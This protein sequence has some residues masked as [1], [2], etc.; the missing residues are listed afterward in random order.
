MLPRLRSLSFA[1]AFL[2]VA[3]VAVAAEHAPARTAARAAAIV[4]PTPEDVAALRGGSD[5]SISP[6]GTRLVYSLGTATLDP[7][8]RPNDKDTDGGWKRDRQVWIV[9]LAGGPPQQLTHGV[10]Q[11][12]S[13]VWSPDGREVAFLR[14]VKGKSVLHVIV[15]AGGEAQVVPTGTLEPSSVRWSPDGK[16]FAFLASAESSKQK[17]EEKWR[18]GGVVDWGREYESTS[19]WVVP[20]EGGEP[21]RL[22][23]DNE[24]VASFEWSPDGTRFAV[25]S[26]PS[27]D[28]YEESNH[29]T[30]R[31]IALKDGATIGVLAAKAEDYSNLRWSPDGRKLA[32]LT[33]HESLSME[34]ELRVYDLPNG[35]ARNALPDFEHTVSSFVWAGDGRSVVALV[36]ERTFTKLV[37]FPVDGGAGEDLGFSGRVADAPLTIDRS[38]DQLA[39][40]SSTE[41]EPRDPTVFAIGARDLR[42]V[43]HLNP[44]VADWSL[45]REEVVH[46]KSENGIDVEGLLL[47][48]P[49]AKAGAPAPLLVMPHGGPDD[50]SASSFS[51]LGQFFAAH[52]ISV[53]RPNY[54]GSF[55]YGHDF[56]AAN[57]GRFGE[58]E[59]KDIESGVDALIAAKKA[60][61]RRLLYGG[62]S[63]G[64][65][66]TAWTIGHT[67]RYRAAVVGAGV[68]DVFVQY[69]LSDIN[70]GD[71]AAWEYRGN[72]WLQLENFDRANPIRYARDMKTPTLILH[73][74]SDPR[75]GFAAS[76]EL[77]RALLDMGVPTRFYAYPRE[78]HNFTEPAH[79]V[80]RTRVW[81]EWYETFLKESARPI[82]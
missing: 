56:Y 50:V 62:W 10:E 1:A 31:V 54:R 5:L 68:N 4:H 71:A 23:K 34:N 14:K 13:P 82:P 64:G 7:D 78:P 27:G 48:S 73:G 70:H 6:D 65:Y 57:R 72:P 25:L 33:T 55:G 9:D 77:Y 80:H 3:S 39:F 38:G 61:A 74:Q 45:G 20:R 24:S 35:P 46:W 17:D 53:F 36:R 42:V 19:L 51:S 12:R 41:R 58:I 79:V 43:A 37:R 69:S 66:I 76:E 75:V 63:W 67:N 8:V 2:L 49:A 18:T 26:A 11:A 59:F 44:Q 28:P 60:D 47:V 30:P 32:V 81:L 21:R 22:T 40:F 52:G 16:W 15:L 29:L